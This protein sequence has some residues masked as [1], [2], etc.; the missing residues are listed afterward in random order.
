M[1]RRAARELPRLFHA[2][3]LDGRFIIDIISMPRGGLFHL[4]ASAGAAALGRKGERCAFQAAGGAGA[5]CRWDM[6]PARRRRQR[7]AA[8]EAGDYAAAA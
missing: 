4:D 8:E 5:R 1:A 6:I 7:A 2:L 3:L